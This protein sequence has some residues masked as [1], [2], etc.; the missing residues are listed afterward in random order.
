MAHPVL[1]KNHLTRS[2]LLII[3]H[4]H[5]CSSCP[6]YFKP[7]DPKLG[8]SNQKTSIPCVIR[9]QNQPGEEPFSTKLLGH[10]F[11]SKKCS[12]AASAPHLRLP[13]LKEGRAQRILSAIV[14]LG[15]FIG[16]HLSYWPGYQKRIFLSNRVPKQMG[17][18]GC[19][20]LFRDPTGFSFWNPH[21]MENLS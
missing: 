16:H 9:R 21:S 1:T 7:V 6:L 13:P 11:D 20:K 4:C 18:N 14:Y 17:L 12:E 10:F 5:C 3:N 19:S 2:W 15:S 8:M